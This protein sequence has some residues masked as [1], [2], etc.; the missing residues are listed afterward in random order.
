MKEFIHEKFRWELDEYKSDDIVDLLKEYA[1]KEENEINFIKP[2]SDELI[3]FF[4]STITKLP[5]DLKRLYMFTNGFFSPTLDVLPI[6]DGSNVKKTWDSINKANSKKT[7]FVIQNEL[8][9]RF[10]I[11]GATSSTV[12][13]ALLFDKKDFK[14]YY[15]DI[16]DDEIK[17]TNLNFRDLILINLYGDYMQR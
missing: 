5:E 14:F 2:A 11:F 16:C 17:Q 13:Q 10:C 9:D 1:E 15:Q 4:E 12:S 6:F 7:K 3:S 8:F